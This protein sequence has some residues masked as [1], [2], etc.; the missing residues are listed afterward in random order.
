[1]REAEIQDFELAA[2]GD[3]DVARLDV[4]VNHLALVRMAQPLQ[5]VAHQPQLAFQR[6]VSR[7]PMMFLRSSPSRNSMAM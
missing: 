4:A 1:M 3:V 6:E 5:Q 7:R 2:A